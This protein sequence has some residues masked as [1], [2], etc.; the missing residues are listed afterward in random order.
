MSEFD[1]EHLIGGFATNTL[2]ESEHQAL[3]RAAMVNQRL[4]DLLADEQALKELLD[5]P[6]VRRRLLQQLKDPQSSVHVGWFDQAVRW[7]TR[8]DTLAVSGSL[9][10]LALATFFGLNLYRES[11]QIVRE[12]AAKPG[13]SDV[14]REPTVRAK[15]NAKAPTELSPQD[16]RA[17]QARADAEQRPQSL[18]A[19]E[20][21]D[22]SLTKSP[23]RQSAPDEAGTQVAQA[24]RAGSTSAS[25]PAQAGQ[26]AQAHVDDRAVS[27]AQAAAPAP[28]VVLPRVPPSLQKKRRADSKAAS[29]R[30][31]ESGLPK[32]SSVQSPAV[33]QQEPPQTGQPAQPAMEKGAADDLLPELSPAVGNARTVFYA[34]ATSP[35]VAAPK[36]EQGPSTPTQ[37][38]STMEAAQPTADAAAPPSS[39]TGMDRTDPIDATVNE[40]STAGS[41]SN[42]SPP[43]PPPPQPL[44]IRYYQRPLPLQGAAARAE[45][46]ALRELTLQVN[47]PG[48][49]YV[50]T[51]DAHRGWTVLE[52]ARTAAAKGLA[53]AEARRTYRVLMT[54]AAT[55][56]PDHRTYLVFSRQP[57]AALEQALALMGG[58]RTEAEVAQELEQLLRP[59]LATYPTQSLTAEQATEPTSGRKTGTF[60][61]VAEAGERAH[62]RLIYRIP[63]VP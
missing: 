34:E 10:V 39:Q 21:T 35:K 23:R 4:F 51:R 14:L 22:T 17:G 61:Y 59:L 57:E 26:S 52:P 16:P 18:E 41:P 58:T 20:T 19:K 53:T 6:A 49:V 24:T 63:P 50:I 29:V 30:S 37:A 32:D 45:G 55:P 11:Q 56:L 42:D 2:T 7:A 1:L 31:E 25:S 33:A 13:L 3:F 47:Q 40:A 62:D 9:A 60:T 48:F 38:S 28:P 15:L 12:E 36:P 5:D 8:W 46:L 44:A 43:P 54:S 27:A